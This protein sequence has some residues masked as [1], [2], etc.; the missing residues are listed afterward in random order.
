MDNKP[1]RQG[2][3]DQFLDD[4]GSKKAAPGGG[5]A[6]GLVGAQACALAEMVCHLTES[7]KNYAEFHEKAAEYAAVFQMAR[8]IFLD[9]MDED[10]KSFLELMNTLR[11]IRPLPLA[12]RQEKQLDAFRFVTRHI[13][14]EPTWLTAP[15]Y[16]NRITPNPQRVSNNLGT[17][18][19][20]TLVSPALLNRLTDTYPASEYL[21]ALLR[22]TF[23]FKPQT[24]PYRQA[25]QRKA[26]VGLIEYFEAEKDRDPWPVV[27]QQLRWLRS[28]CQTLQGQAHYAALAD[29]IDRALA[30]DK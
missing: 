11:A 26:V 6:A 1:F 24:S 8:S 22:A 7:N 13:L 19:M 30:V 10:A 18:F 20:A 16:M 3:I 12:E 14:E 4:L 17:R 25:L 28:R 9:L 23:D 15:D 29:M 21:P 2:T 5:A 27:L